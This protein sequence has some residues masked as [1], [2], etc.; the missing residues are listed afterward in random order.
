MNYNYVSIK[1]LQKINIKH[2]FYMQ[3][4]NQAMQTFVTM[5]ILYSFHH[6]PSLKELNLSNRYDEKNQIVHLELLSQFCP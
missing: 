1:I 3:Y 5:M 6:F 2:N 4:F